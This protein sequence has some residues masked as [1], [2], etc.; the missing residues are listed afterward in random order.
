M[1]EGIDDFHGSMRIAARGLDVPDVLAT[2]DDDLVRAGD[3][4]FCRE[5]GTTSIR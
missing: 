4:P 2:T 1:D 5:P 3:L